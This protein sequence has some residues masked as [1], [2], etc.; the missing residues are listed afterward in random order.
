MSLW[1]HFHQLILFKDTVLNIHYWVI[2]I[3][4]LANNTITHLNKA[5]LTQ[6]FF[7]I[8]L[9]IVVF[10]LGILD[11]TS[12]LCLED[13]LNSHSTNKKHKNVKSMA[14]SRLGKGKLF[15]VGE[16]NRMQSTALFDLGWAH[17]TQATRPFYCSVH[18]HE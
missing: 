6:E 2:H 11:R 17:A 7:S 12:A 1:P 13:I 4:L 10:C 16:R 18:V 15:A 14:Q 9:I 5:Y 8:R 3:E